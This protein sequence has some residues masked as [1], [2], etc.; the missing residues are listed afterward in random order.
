MKKKI[1]AAFG[2]LLIFLALAILVWSSIHEFLHIAA[3]KYF[4]YGYEL[5]W[6]VLLPQVHCIGC[7]TTNRSQMFIYSFLPYTLDIIV[8]ALG[9]SLYKFKIARYLMHFGYFDIISNYFSMLLALLY[10]T[11]NDFLNLI[12]LGFWS[13]VIIFFVSSTFLWFSKN[14]GI[15][16]D[17]AKRYKEIFG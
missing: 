8:V 17:Y 16:V 1:F 6:N 11:P 2:E 7:N 13:F 12:R 14:K 3:L 15:I 4:G 10:N 9:F 5:R